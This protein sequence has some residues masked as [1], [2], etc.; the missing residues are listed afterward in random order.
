[1][2]EVIDCDECDGL[3]FRVRRCVCVQG[4]DQLIVDGDRCADQAYADCRVCGGDSSV[5]EPCG[6]CGRAGRR[7]AQLVVTVVNLDTGAAASRRLLPGRLDPPAGPDSITRARDIVTELAA[8]VG[9]R[10]IRPRWGQC[11]PDDAVY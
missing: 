10:G 6:R 5:V 3:G 9:V 11:A 4:G 7:R 2:L 8:T 1:M